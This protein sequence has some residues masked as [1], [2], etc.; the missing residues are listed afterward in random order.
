MSEKCPDFTC[1]LPTQPTIRMGFCYPMVPLLISLD[2][3]LSGCRQGRHGR[4]LSRLA[5]PA[6]PPL[7]RDRD[8]QPSCGMGFLTVGPTARHISGA[9]RHPPGGSHG[10][11]A[12]GPR[13]T[14]C[15]NRT[16]RGRR[17]P[18]FSA[19]DVAGTT[20][21]GDGPKD[22]VADPRRRLAADCPAAKGGI[23][24]ASAIPKS[25]VRPTHHRPGCRRELPSWRRGRRPA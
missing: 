14:A 5:Q 2:C 12:H 25:F 17:S 8:H 16:N 11:P 1:L 19:A 3:S 13:A 10:R 24:H 9:D 23:E 21:E 18:H 7:T 22:A 20:R 4:V 15:G 6:S